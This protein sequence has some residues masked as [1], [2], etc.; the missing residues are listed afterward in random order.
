MYKDKENLGGRL[1]RCREKAS[2][3]QR[4]LG[5][6]A[7]KEF[8]KD[9]FSWQSISK[10]ESNEVIP[11]PEY[12]N[13]LAILFDVKTSWLLTGIR[14]RNDAD[15]KL[16]NAYHGLEKEDQ[17]MVDALIEN[18]QNKYKKEGNGQ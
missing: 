16:L 5:K 12:L 10:W 9:A 4:Q 11:S 2:L 6:L 15:N 7:E 1:A 18:F 8:G 14:T 13:Q 17:K 3:S